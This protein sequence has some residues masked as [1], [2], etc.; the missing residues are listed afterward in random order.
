MKKFFSICLIIALL[1]LNGCSF[2]V[3]QDTFSIP[4]NTVSSIEIQKEYTTEDGQTFYR[5]KVVDG[6]E[7][8]E[9]ICEMIRTLPAEKVPAGEQTAIRSTPL[10]IIMR[11]EIEH[12]LILNEERAF[13]N[14]MAYNYLD[15]D[16]FEDFMDLYDNLAYEES[17]TEAK[18][19]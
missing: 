15:S 14:Q 7:D 3:K 12:R 11:S 1:M 18:P 16:T 9:K 8:V 5:C 6:I 17:D 19:L 10:I 4:E 13:Y 2:K